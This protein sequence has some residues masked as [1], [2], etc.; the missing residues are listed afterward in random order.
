[1]SPILSYFQPNSE[2][3]KTTINLIQFSINNILEKGVNYI[4]YWENRV[5]PFGIKSR[6]FICLS[7]KQNV[8]ENF[9]QVYGEYPL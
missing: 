3:S 9:H 5:M 8:V 6:N 7:F 2:W 1:M 4:T